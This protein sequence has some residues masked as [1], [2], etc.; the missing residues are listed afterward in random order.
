MTLSST[1]QI[2]TTTAVEIQNTSDQ[3]S[4]IIAGAI[5]L[6][7]GICGITANMTA[8]KII[9]KVPSLKNCFGY[10]LLLHASAE[11]SVMAIFI[12]WA[13]PVTFL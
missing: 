2:P 10:F 4:D 9:R 1:S 6:L 3:T 7:V 5:L 12:F 8:I 11:A 13:A